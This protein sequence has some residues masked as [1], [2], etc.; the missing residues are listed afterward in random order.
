MPVA[1][2]LAADAPTT[3]AEADAGSGGGGIKS[4]L[5][6]LPFQRNENKVRQFHPSCHAAA[7]K[8]LRFAM[9]QLFHNFR[10]FFDVPQ[11]L[12]D[13]KSG[14]CKV[15]L[16]RSVGK[17]STGT[18][19]EC[20]I[21]R[22]Y[23]ESI[24]AA[25][26][27]VYIESQFFVGDTAG[28]GVENNIPSTLVERI[29]RAHANREAFRVIVI[30]PMH[31][32]GD[33]VSA[34]KAKVV[35]HFEYATINR[36]LGCLFEQLLKKAPDISISKY[37]GF[38]SLRNWGVINGKV[39]SDQIYV[40]DKLLIVDDRVAI[41]GSANIND[42]SM[43]GMR[44][45]EVA[46]RIEDTLHIDIYMNRQPF[47]VGY[48]PH[49]LR[50]R[51]MRQH[52]GV[53]ESVDVSDVLSEPVMQMWTR[54]AQSNSSLYDSL[55]GGIS[56]YRCSTIADF[57]S[58]FAKYRNPSYFDPE[59]R[60]RVDMIRGF[61]VDWPRDLFCKEDLSPSLATRTIIP[62]ELWV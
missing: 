16:L 9:S 10:R 7:Q 13:G 4:P 3:D 57:T 2:A 60:Q 25:K 62:N 26:H 12:T 27:F 38:F 37:I 32:N 28:E 14:T 44:D 58:A 41:I 48:F 21:L 22:C 56:Y 59:T 6:F 49:M 34:S 20:S 19:T 50:T 53:N 54:T 52:L 30:I 39:V 5:S 46:V 43:L 36:G 18:K 45:S 42:R 40:H 29:L 17:W 23:T 55:D 47:A 11:R 31:P 1:V 24:K 61:L 51:L 15:Q 33:F 8:E 35:M